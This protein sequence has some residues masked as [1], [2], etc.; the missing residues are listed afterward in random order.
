MNFKRKSTALS[1]GL[2]ASIQAAGCI[3]QLAFAAAASD[4][5]V[6]QA[7]AAMLASPASA[8]LAYRYARAALAAGD[9]SAAIAGLER[10]LLL[11]PRRDNIRRD[12]GELYAIAG[13]SARAEPLLVR[14]TNS[15]SIPADVRT[16]SELMI[17][18]LR[19]GETGDGLRL[20]PKSQFYGRLYLGGAY[21]TNPRQAPTEIAI[22][23]ADQSTLDTLS[24][25]LAPNSQPEDDFSLETSLNA[26]YET[27]LGDTRHS[28][29]ASAAAFASRHDETPTNDFSIFTGDLGLSLRGPGG[30]MVQPFLRTSNIL[31][32]D[33]FFSTSFGGGLSLAAPFSERFYGSVRLTAVN[34][35]Y[36]VVDVAPLGDELDGRRYTLDASLQYALK[37]S[38]RFGVNAVTGYKDAQEDFETFS[39]FGGGVF[40][41]HVTETF[42]PQH[43]LTL[44]AR[45]N[46]ER[47]LYEAPEP[48]IDPTQKRKDD[49]YSIAASA[50]FALTRRVNLSSSL[51]YVDRDSTLVNFDFDN[52]GVRLGA[53]VRF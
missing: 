37:R 39:R 22:A 43:P 30:I 20:P 11:D 3:G 16:R 7:Y 2:V 24:V 31:L 17:E 45:F 23:G 5:E 52:F 36:K 1:L 27:R 8:E 14:A 53:S 26:T 34:E 35:D 28:I 4:G 42:G 49:R 47:S 13:N 33:E 50:D 6:E 29:Y 25:E 32:A 44:T 19:R 46:Y 41:T 48:R 40:A 18:A 15:A 9:L 21:Q 38:T 51:E 12:L 10:V